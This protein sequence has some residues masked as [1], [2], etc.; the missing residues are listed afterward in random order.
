VRYRGAGTPPAA[1]VARIRGL[2][3]ASVVDESPRM[4]ALEA[5][6]ESLAAL[7][8]ELDDWIV[9]PDASHPLPDTRKRIEGPPRSP[10][11]GLGSV[12]RTNDGS[13]DGRQR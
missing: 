1:D 10:A 4:L 11:T 8:D 12:Q 2:D 13:S 9:A 3:G 6:A 5:P 7:V